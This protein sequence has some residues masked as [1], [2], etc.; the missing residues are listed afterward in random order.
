MPRQKYLDWSNQILNVCQIT[1]FLMKIQFGMCL[2]FLCKHHHPFR[3]EAWGGSSCSVTLA[4]HGP[5]LFCL[6]A[7]PCLGYVMAWGG[8]AMDVC[9]IKSHI[10]YVASIYEHS[11]HLNKLWI[12]LL[13]M[14]VKVTGKFS[15]RIYFL[16]YFKKIKPNCSASS[17]CPSLSPSGL[18][19]T[20][21]TTSVC[22]ALGSTSSPG[23]RGKAAR[24]GGQAAARLR[25]PGKRR[26][27]TDR[28]V[29]LCSSAHEHQ[30]SCLIVLHTYAHLFSCFT[31]ET[32]HQ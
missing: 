3:K 31:F 6:W 12:Y 23:K 20:Q 17:C 2:S 19:Y 18:L 9:F 22:P 24:R 10:N 25:P 32:W 14:N 30:T 7:A 26:W 13:N 15:F 27:N 4:S 1:Y 8:S 5:V 28:S 29:R 16:S 11:R 21:Q